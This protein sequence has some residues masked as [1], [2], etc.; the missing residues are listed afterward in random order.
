LEASAQQTGAH[1]PADQKAAEAQ[2]A[3]VSPAN[4]GAA[5]AKARQVN[6]MKAAEAPRADS[7][8]FLALLRQEI[9]RVMPQNLDDATR[10]MQ[11]G[12]K[13]QIKS[14]V[15]GA[16][17]DQ[18]DAAAGPTEQA[19]RTTP[20]PN[21]ETARQAE[22]L[23]E[24]STK[25]PLPINA[26]EAM[27]AP[28]SAAEV[29]SL[30]RG[31]QALATQFEA[32]KLTPEQLQKANDPRFSAVLV[33]K[34]NVEALAT[35]APGE[36]RASEQATLGQATAVA[37]AETSTGLTQIAERKRAGSSKV[38][39]QQLQSKLK[40]EARRKEVTDTI[41]R[42]YQ[43]TRER[44]D[45]KLSTLEADVM[46]MFDAGAE[47]ALSD[48]QT[49][50]KREI[51]KFYDARYTGM[52]GAAQWLIDRFLPV[53]EEVKTILRQERARFATRMDTLAQQIAAT[54]DGRLAEAKAEVDKGQGE[55]QRYVAS[56]PK[57][58]R[59]VGLQ[60]EQAIAS[61]FD[62][63]R[64]GIDAR[65]TELAQKLAQKYK[66][67]HDS[68]DAALKK[69]EE[70]NEGALKGLGD[71][72]GEVVKVLTELKQKLMGVLRQG[73]ETLELILKDPL[74][75]LSNLISAVK[76]GFQQFVANIGAHLSRG[77]M[78]WL[79][80]AL[81]QAGIQ[82]PSDLTPPSLL[83]LVLSV[84][85]ITYER[86][87]AKAVRLLGERT[88][89][90]MEKVFELVQDFVIRGPAAMWEQLKE[91][92]G[93]LKAQV[94]D[95]LKDWLTETVVKQAVLRMLSMFNP[96][97]AIV[98][99][100]MAIYNTVMF[101]IE[102]AGQ[103]A[104]LGEAVIR[105]V[106]SIATGA[107]GGAANWIEQ[108]LGRAVPVVIGFLARLIGL[109]NISGK[110]RETIQKIQGAVDRAIDRAIAKLLAVAR[111][112]LRKPGL[113]GKQEPSH[114]DEG[115]SPSEV[116]ATVR[117]RA[118][119]ESHRL[120]IE[121]HGDSLLVMVASQETPVADKIEEWDKSLADKSAKKGPKSKNQRKKAQQLIG[122]AKQKLGLTQEEG[123]EAKNESQEAVRKKTATK[124]AQAKKANDEAKNAEQSLAQIL[125][126]LFALF[127]EENPFEHGIYEL[128]GKQAAERRATGK[129][130]ALIKK[131]D[132]P[133]EYQFRWTTHGSIYIQRTP[134]QVGNVPD[135][136]I[137]EHGKLQEGLGKPTRDLSWLATEEV[138]KEV[139]KEAE[140]A[141]AESRSR[142]NESPK[143]AKDDKATFMWAAVFATT[144]A[145][146]LKKTGPRFESLTL[147]RI[148]STTPGAEQRAWELATEAI[149]KATK[150]A[151]EMKPDQ[152]MLLAGMVARDLLDR[153][154]QIPLYFVTPT[155]IARDLHG[156]NLGLV[157]T[158]K[159][160]RHSK[161]LYESIAQNSGD[162]MVNLAAN[163]TEKQIHHVVPLYL[164]GPHAVRNLFSATGDAKVAHDVPATAHKLMHDLIDKTQ[165]SFYL[166]AKD[167]EFTSKLSFTD[168]AQTLPADQLKLLMGTLYEDGHIDYQERPNVKVKVP[169]TYSS[170]A[171]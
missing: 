45:A 7:S 146:L 58:L 32:A 102:R 56:L 131:E 48:L 164:G 170:K 80:G 27:P 150:L 143:K 140:G 141:R 18:K 108:A 31:N 160:V 87:R 104:V 137:D 100:V 5:G 122:L 21:G 111:R 110:I 109:G 6:V 50:A 69:L 29:A 64:S 92:L 35:K 20:V 151:P 9:E 16:V 72:I 101:F 60:A 46:R 26:A 66:E 171:E 159:D 30:Q 133:K 53:P 82:T 71:A 107:I 152:H 97:G 127:G 88:V 36:Y 86:M 162:E 10:F 76:A 55:I 120:W 93:D 41:E 17:R 77:F 57:D 124:Q 52:E 117:F 123:R 89:G 157:K 142:K 39:A 139:A 105:S 129:D 23:R 125:T 153:V 43:Q 59:E 106:H 25:A 47:A 158:N 128:I 144:G 2:A 95:S 147:E 11:R 19:A 148:W 113:D 13:G 54:V 78:Q 68:A 34:G 3:A 119:G 167:K 37:T 61:R 81:E 49:S 149:I 44:V 74:Q 136:S 22:P 42:I 40:D 135:V 67:A 155:I 4:E 12:E 85:G 62:E 132:L 94:V 38:M 118:A 126:E 8:G 163:V 70:E 83:K 75:F 156:Q 24:E 145:K 121:T 154:A 96:V 161:A 51:D 79:F 103:I 28:R 15:S 114:A 65:A 115:A 134:N 33:A 130:K 99:A 98:Q 73:A 91:N 112:L 84:L 166:A 116:G 63:M 169:A 90:L 1:P 14:A 165:V 138:K 168:L